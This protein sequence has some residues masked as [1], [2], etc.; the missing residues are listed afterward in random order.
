MAT[1]KEI[2]GKQVKFLSSDPANEG[3]GQVWYNSTSNVF[4]TVVSSGAWASSA[5]IT[6]ARLATAST[7]TQTA[8]LLM[9]GS[10]PPYATPSALVEEYN[11]TGWTNE[12]SL[13]ASLME[14]AAAGTTTAALIAGGFNAPPPPG[15]NTSYEYD[16]STWTASPGNLNNGRTNLGSG[17]T[18]AAAVVFGG[19][20]APTP[21]RKATEEYNGSTWASGNDMGNSRY[22]MMGNN[23]GLQTAALAIGGYSGGAL[24]TVEEYDGTNWTATTALPT[25]GGNQVR[26]GLST[27]AVCAGGGPGPGAN[28]DVKE[29]DGST[30]TATPSLATGRDSNSGSGTPTAGVIGGA[31][32]FL[33]NT[34]EYNVGT[35]VVVPGAWASGGVLNTARTLGGSAIPSQSAGIIFGGSPYTGATEQYNGS[36]WTTVPGTLNTARGYNSGF[37]TET[38]AVCAGGYTTPP[39][40]MSFVEEYNGTSW[41]EETNLPTT[42]KNAG[43]CGILTAGLLMGGSTAQPFAPNVVDTSLHYDGTNWTAGGTMPVGRGQGMSG[44]VQTA[45][46]Y[47]GGRT[48]PA[49]VATTVEYNG[50]SFSAGGDLAFGAGPP[51]GFQGSIGTLTAG[52]AASGLT[53][54]NFVNI[55]D[56]TSWFS[57]PSYTT[58]RNR[59]FSGGTQTA[60]LIAGGATPGPK[61]DLTE[62]FTGATTAANVQTITTS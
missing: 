26:Y 57:S 17:G 30:W 38:A 19:S 41:S 58:Y 1:Y 2:F 53:A 12:T 42:L 22:Q 5:P 40:G 13:P 56:G 15:L 18:Q 10:L 7:G 55:Y 11:G 3:E 37:G 36:S 6:S 44:G 32:P 33:S 14:G 60:A 27:A 52:L 49:Y 35:T 61:S 25:A 16:G 51:S 45:A 50:S 48:A 9:A 34:E 21:M 20:E 28:T 59:G 39:S 29:F 62:E 8:S 24:S 46:F 54:G 47:A 43:N 4:K 23:V 31:T